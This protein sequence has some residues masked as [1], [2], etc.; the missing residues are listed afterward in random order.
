[1]SNKTKQILI[2]LVIGIVVSFLFYRYG[3]SKKRI[4]LVEKRAER[5]QLT[6]KINEAKSVVAQ[7]DDFREKVRKVELK[8]KRAQQMLPQEQEIPS[9]LK[10]IA[11][12]GVIQNVEILV[13]QKSNPVQ[14]EHYTE[15]PVQLQ[16]SGGYHDIGRFLSSIGNL[17]RIV[18][19]ADLRINPET[20]YKIRA[21]FKATTYTLAQTEPKAKK[22]KRSR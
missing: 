15:I 22:K 5:Q 17:S 1:M 7:L 16:V 19:V 13:F 18:T 20:G 4:L 8:W 2:V 10:S 12:S 9:L 21:S 3:I 14:Q 11:E 6:L